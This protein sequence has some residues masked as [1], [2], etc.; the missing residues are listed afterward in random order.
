[1]Q[2]TADGLWRLALKP[3]TPEPPKNKTSVMRRM[4]FA[5]LLMVASVFLSRMVGFIREMVIA[6]QQ[7]AT[8]ATDA[9]FA[10]FTLPDMLNYFLAGGTLTI[11]FIPL[12]SEYLARGDEDGGWDLFS[13][14]ATGTGSLLLLATLFGLWT[15]PWLVP[16]LTPGFD[17]EQLELCVR[18]TR[19]VMPG[20]ICF[21]IGGLLQATLLA[22]ERFAHVAAIPIVYNLMIIAGG[23]VLGPWVGIEGF[24]WGALAGSVIGPL[25]I[26]VWASRG[27]LRYSPRFNF[28]SKG[29]VRYLKLALPLMIGVSLISLDEWFLK[30]FGSELD[31]G[32]ISWLNNARRLMLVPVAIVGQ[33]AGQAAMPFLSRLWSEGRTDEMAQTLTSAVRSVLF[34]AVLAATAL[35]ALAQPVVFVAFH[36]GEFT[37]EDASGTAVLLACFC[38]GIASW[39]VQGLVARGFY[40]RHDTLRPMLLGTTV[41]ALSLP[42]YAW[43]G[44]TMGGPGLALASCAGITLNTLTLIFFFRRWCAPINIGAIAGTL[45]AALACGLPAG[46]AAW[47]L[48]QYL[49]QH[50]SLESTWQGTIILV[51]SAA[52]FGAIS[53]GLAFAMKRDE[54]A[55]LKR[56]IARVTRRKAAAP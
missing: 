12:F 47:G 53:L 1:M 28:R 18:M 4:G 33:A 6:A 19:I 42:L 45:A 22:R 40:A 21:G 54:L 35:A 31:K 49:S 25:L 30:Y 38:A 26:P 11:T 34:Y 7:G 16:L 43:L 10:A 56:I 37:A 32:T 20:M 39:S 15:A 29:F 52:A 36:R 41:A 3:A 23:V 51:V 9:Y 2:S 44:Q 24:A 5:T 55:F 48:V 14:V 17:A 13:T 50:L 27:Q 46:A 8:G